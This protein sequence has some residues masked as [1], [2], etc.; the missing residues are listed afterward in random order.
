M[1]IPARHDRRQDLSKA[2]K[3]VPFGVGRVLDLTRHGH[4]VLGRRTM[5]GGWGA[6]LVPELGA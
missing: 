6:L 4:R 3:A 1:P 2:T 5:I